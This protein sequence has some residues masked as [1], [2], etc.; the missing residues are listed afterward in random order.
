MKRM[1]PPIR[2][3]AETPKIVRTAAW[4][5]LVL[6]VV[7]VIAPRI[8]TNSEA[9]AMLF[10][11]P[12]ALILALGSAAA[13]RAYILARREDRPVRWTAFLPLALFVAAMG[14]TLLL[15]FSDLGWGTGPRE[16]MPGSQ[17][18]SQ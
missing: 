5:N 1:K 2:G 4:I 13:I 8:V 6:A 7:A 11:I 15:V 16:V 9:A 17:S 3:A 18:G 10:A 14:L 12:M